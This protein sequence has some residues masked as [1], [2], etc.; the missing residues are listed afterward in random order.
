[1]IDVTSSD[2]RALAPPN[3]FEQMP[4]PRIAGSGDKMRVRGGRGSEIGTR[5]DGVPVDNALGGSSGKA[6]FNQSRHISKSKKTTVTPSD[7]GETFRYVGGK[8][9]VKT[10]DGWKDLTYTVNTDP[11]EIEYLS[12][13]YFD[14]LKKHPDIKEFLALGENVTFVYKDKTYKIVKTKEEKKK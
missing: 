12:E 7:R 9:F 13:E 4:R 14:L 8:T 1:M 11:I 2:A 5:I 3:Q 10:E 6:S